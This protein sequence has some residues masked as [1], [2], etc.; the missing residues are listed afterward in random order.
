MKRERKRI[1]E[2]CGVERWRFWWESYFANTV[3][4]YPYPCSYSVIHVCIL[5]LNTH[6]HTHTHTHTNIYIYIYIFTHTHT[7]THRDIHTQNYNVVKTSEEAD[8][9]IFFKY[10]LLNKQFV[11][12]TQAKE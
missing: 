4:S 11:K 1:R 2:G 9:I 7:H 10:Y 8:K 6:T 5:N 12:L 3:Y